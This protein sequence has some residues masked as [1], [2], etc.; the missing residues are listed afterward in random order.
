MSETC[1]TCLDRN[2]WIKCFK[3]DY[4]QESK[5]DFIMKNCSVKKQL[6]AGNILQCRTALWRN[7]RV[8]HSCLNILIHPLSYATLY[9]LLIKTKLI[10]FIYHKNCIRCS[11]FKHNV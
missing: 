6:Q 3:R 1:D 8:L 10:P 9:S 5:K 4:K 2:I 11:I 7:G